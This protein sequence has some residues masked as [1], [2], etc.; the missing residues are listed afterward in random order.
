MT[1][2]SRAPDECCASLNVEP[3]RVQ[4]IRETW[5]VSLV[6]F[7]HPAGIPLPTSYSSHDAAENFRVKER[8]KEALTEIF[9]ELEFKALGKRILGDDYNVHNK[10]GP[11]DLFGNTI[12][13]KSAQQPARVLSGQG[14]APFFPATALGV[15]GSR[16]RHHL[17]VYVGLVRVVHAV[18]ALA[19]ERGPAQRRVAIAVA[20]SSPGGRDDE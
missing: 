18:A 17:A 3:F 20:Q 2:R 15:G 11:M 12:P 9:A 10:Q 13:Q 5:C 19:K 4:P 14:L 1:V 8:N 7:D 16:A 6:R